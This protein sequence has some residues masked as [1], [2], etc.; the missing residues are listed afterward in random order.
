MFTGLVIIV[1]VTQ[2]AVCDPISDLVTSSEPFEESFPGCGLVTPSNV[3]SE[4]VAGGEK[5]TEDEPLPWM[6]FIC[7]FNENFECE[8]CGGSLISKHHILTAGHCVENKTID[9]VVVTMGSHNAIKSLK[10]RNWLTLAAITIYPGYNLVTGIKYENAPD[11]AILTLEQPVELNAAVNTICLGDGLSQ[12]V[13]TKATVSGW[14]YVPSEKKTSGQKLMK[15]EVSVISNVE[16]KKMIRPHYTF[17]QEY[18]N[19]FSIC[20]NL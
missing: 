19:T 9:E 5:V 3:L 6:A 8:A 2:G 17:I 18:S 7:V 15:V 10:E 1:I 4:T 16:C 14:G 11:I 12:Y 13:D 20:L